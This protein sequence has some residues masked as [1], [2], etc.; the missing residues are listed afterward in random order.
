M[1]RICLL[2]DSRAPSGVGAHMMTLAEGLE[3]DEIV[4]AARAGTGL[5]EHAAAKGA[6]RVSGGDANE[7]LAMQREEGSGHGRRRREG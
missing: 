2:T 1:T 4:V 6:L 5:L 3:A 7:A